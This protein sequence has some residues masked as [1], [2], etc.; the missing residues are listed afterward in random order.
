VKRKKKFR[1]GQRVQSVYNPTHVFVIDKSRVPE[2]IYHEKVS[3]RWWTR[4]ELQRLGA[5]ENPATSIR[6]NGK[7]RMRRTHSNAFPAIPGKPSIVTEVSAGLEKPRC[8]EC[9]LRFQPARPWQK[10]HSEGCRLA[11]WKRMAGARVQTPKPAVR[12]AGELHV[13]RVNSQ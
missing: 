13:A 8:L 10:F 7:S 5:P 11:H 3:N 9:G 2:R 4:N 6:L 1:V 12:R